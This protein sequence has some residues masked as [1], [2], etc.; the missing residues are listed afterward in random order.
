VRGLDDRILEL[1]V[2]GPLYAMIL[3]QRGFLVFHASAVSN[4]GRAIAFL[5]FS[6]QGKST[7]AAAFHF[8]KNHALVTDNALAVSWDAKGKPLAIP[9]QPFLKLSGRTTAALGIDGSE[10]D[11]IEPGS[12]KKKIPARAKKAEPAR[13][14]CL[15]VLKD[16]SEVR[17]EAVTRADA[18]TELVRH[19][20]FPADA[21]PPDS[22]E[23]FSALARLAS[24][25]PLRRVAFPHRWDL[26]DSLMGL[27]ERGR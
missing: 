5:G 19:S 3:K 12:H 13:L 16:G 4:R 15:Y 10:Y 20:Y 2:H 27:I 9:A 23:N 21:F 25:L 24:R 7:L 17:I 11:A 14:G 8:R 18:F 26:L 22:G 1:L 6:G